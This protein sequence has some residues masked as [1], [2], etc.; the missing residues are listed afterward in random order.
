LNG[1]AGDV[2]ERERLRLGG[3]RSVTYPGGRG[4]NQGAI[5]RW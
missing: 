2:G 1:A 4:R 5:V 3:H